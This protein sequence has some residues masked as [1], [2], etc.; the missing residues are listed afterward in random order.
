MD[1]KT[2]M[3]FGRRPSLMI[4]NSLVYEVSVRD[5]HP[6]RRR[7]VKNTE[8]LDGEPKVET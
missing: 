3:R 6:G 5:A 1:R 4:I 8:A 7:R 2:L